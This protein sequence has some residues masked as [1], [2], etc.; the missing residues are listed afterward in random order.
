MV[1]NIIKYQRFSTILLTTFT[2]Q[3]YWWNISI[4]SFSKKYFLSFFPKKI[5]IFCII[6]QGYHRN[7]NNQTN[8]T[9]YYFFIIDEYLRTIQVYHSG[10]NHRYIKGNKKVGKTNLITRFIKDEFIKEDNIKL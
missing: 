1:K 2:G 7:S 4:F 3:K 9:Y 10:T 6:S 5:K 8:I